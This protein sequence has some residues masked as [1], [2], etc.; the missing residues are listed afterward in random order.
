MDEGSMPPTCESRSSGAINIQSTNKNVSQ[1]VPR[2]ITRERNII[3]SCNGR[4]AMPVI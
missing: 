3:I 1:H 4:A 2:I